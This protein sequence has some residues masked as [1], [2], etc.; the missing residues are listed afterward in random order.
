VSWVRV[1]PVFA[2]GRNASMITIGIR[3]DTRADVKQGRL[4]ADIKIGPDTAEGFGWAYGDRIDLQWG[5][6]EHAGLFRLEKSPEGRYTLRRKGKSA[7]ESFTI[8]AV[9]PNWIKT[10]V[11]SDMCAE[12]SR[13]G[14][15][16]IVP[17]PASVA[18]Q[19]G[20]TAAREVTEAQPAAK[21]IKGA[22][23]NGGRPEAIRHH[24]PRAAGAGAPHRGRR[25]GT[26]LP[27]QRHAGGIARPR[28][29]QAADPV[30]RQ[31]GAA[32]QDRD[33][34]CHRRARH[35]PRRHHLRDRRQDIRSQEHSGRCG[36]RAHQRPGR[37]SCECPRASG[38]APRISWR[39]TA[40]ARQRVDTAG[41]V[42]LTGRFHAAGFPPPIGRAVQQQPRASAAPILTPAAASRAAQE[43]D[44]ERQKQEFIREHGVTRAVGT[45]RRVHTA[46]EAFQALDDLGIEYSRRAPY[47]VVDGKRLPVSGIVQHVNGILLQRQVVRVKPGQKMAAAE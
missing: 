15:A 41:G 30:D 10:A 24:C 6:Q 42:F 7:R 25:G 5:E 3:A 45:L 37:R 18:G 28:L 20:A 14:D 31:P 32:G 34:A 26:A 9:V 17:L 43:A 22:G 11:P 2:H 40:K 19:R 23:R 39:W 16:V 12:W 38:I 36:D 27:D 8:Q 33:R 46:E 29:W 4:T 35:G 47:C 1:K 21:P 44:E 13:D